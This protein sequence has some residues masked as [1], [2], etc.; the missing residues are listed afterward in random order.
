MELV[1]DIPDICMERPLGGPLPAVA[2][3]PGYSIRAITMEEGG[4]W[5]QVM[6][7]S[8][9]GYE[10]GDFE[11]VMVY[12]YDFDPS[13]VFLMFDDQGRPC[14]TASSWRHHWRW[15][16][17]VGYVLFVGVARPYQGRGLGYS[18]SLR[19]LH[20]FAAHGLRTAILETYDTD[21]PALK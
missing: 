6:D 3:P 21:L 1:D 8:F 14:A 12:N 5:E 4:L 2:L 19:I 7:Q 11:K 20:D 16:P 9:G 17:G 18:I 15:G 13:R 10:P